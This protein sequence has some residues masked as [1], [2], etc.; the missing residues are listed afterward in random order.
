MAFLAVLERSWGK[1]SSKIGRFLLFI[2]F[3][4]FRS[5]FLWEYYERP[6]KAKGNG[7][8]GTSDSSFGQAVKTFF[9]LMRGFWQ[10]GRVN[11]KENL[12]SLFFKSI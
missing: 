3:F 4:C 5:S 10:A 2:D 6:L 9:K 12:T 11:K 1:K 8:K 7:Q